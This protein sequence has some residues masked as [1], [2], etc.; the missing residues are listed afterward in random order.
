MDFHVRP[1][2]FADIAPMH[3][4]RLAVAENRLSSSARVT[5]ASYRPYVE[6]GSAWVAEAAG[7][8]VGF[9]VV[10][11]PA[12]SL[13][14]LFVRPDLEGQGI[15]RSLFETATRWATQRRLGSF[16]L[17]TSPGTR[18]EAFYRAAGLTP[19]GTTEEGEVRFELMLGEAVPPGRPK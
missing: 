8:I 10:D 2:T 7:E 13:W 14:A 5:E 1:A 12:R 17:V 19:A 9:V 16:W 6:C 15:A 18:A 4:I 3:R 11:A